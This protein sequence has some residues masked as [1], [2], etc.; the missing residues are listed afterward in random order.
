M[1]RKRLFVLGVDGAPPKENVPSDVVWASSG[2][3]GGAFVFGT[4]ERA[5]DDA[6]RALRFALTF[7][8][9]PH[10]ATVKYVN[11]EIEAGKVSLD[12]EKEIQPELKRVEP[13]EISVS[14]DLAKVYERVFVFEPVE[15]EHGILH[16]LCGDRHRPTRTRGLRARYGRFIG[17]KPE[18]DRL[19]ELLAQVQEDQ[20]QVV[21]LV[22]APGIGKTR[23]KIAF[24]E[25]LPTKGIEHHEGAFQFRKKEPYQA[26]RQ[27]VQAL[28]ETHG[29][30]LDIL[31]LTLGEFD[32]LDLL[33]KPEKVSDRFEGL[34]EDDLKKGLFFAVRKFLHRAA[35]TPLVLIFEDV[36]WA[37]SASIEL[38]DY[39]IEGVEKTKLLLILVHRPEID[40]PWKKKLNYSEIEVGPFETPEFEEFVKDTVRVDRIPRE[41]SST[42]ESVSL[43]NPLFVEEMVRHLLTTGAME[44]QT[45]ENEEK[46]LAGKASSAA[47]IPTTIHALIASRF[48]RLP[49]SSREALRWAAILGGSFEYE[50]Y[51]DLLRLAVRGEVPAEFQRLV[52]HRYLVEKSVF[53]THQVQFAHDLIHAVILENI[54]PVE[55][56]KM[57]CTIGEFLQKRYPNPSYE[58]LTRI[59]EHFF[60][61]E[62]DEKAVRVGL[63]AGEAAAN[64]YR[65]PEAARYLT[66]VKK[67]WEEKPVK[68]ISPHQLYAPLV[69]VLLNVAD[70]E[71]TERALAEWEKKKGQ[72]PPDAEAQLAYLEMCLRIGQTRYSE[73]LAASDRAVKSW[74]RVPDGK[75]RILSIVPERLLCFLRLGRSEAAISEGSKALEQLG[76]SHTDIRV[77]ILSRLAIC[78]MRMGARDLALDHIR[79]TQELITLN[80]PPQVRTACARNVSVVFEYLYMG[81]EALTPISEAIEVAQSTGLRNE[82]LRLIAHRAGSAVEWGEYTFALS[83]IATAL[84]ECRL[85]KDRGQEELLLFFWADTLA[86]LGAADEAMSKLEL[87]EKEFPKVLDPRVEAQ[88]SSLRGFLAEQQGLFQE[89][90]RFR[91]RGADLYEQLGDST[92]AARFRFQV[93]KIEARGNL[94]PTK[95]LVEIFN[96]LAAA[97]K[98]AMVPVWQHAQREAAYYLAS[99]GGKPTPGPE[100]EYDPISCPNAYFRQYLSVAKIHWLDSIGKRKEADELRTR[101]RAERERM[102]QKIPPQYH[103]TFDNHP[104]YRVPERKS[105]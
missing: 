91:T 45:L 98:D 37:D 66:E 18:L 32:Y 71:T 89:A 19:M 72:Q 26:F 55:A 69:R 11:V 76:D 79:K 51:L 2:P 16:L 92:Y 9:S 39:L 47:Q 77:L 104:L 10:R 48:D 8:E 43:G 87:L 31:G 86:D 33:V 68:E 56:R 81:P 29:T 21:G 59:A 94:R 64:L 67:R 73:A 57:H 75:F 20:G 36:H 35:K 58:M 12:W 84:A 82:L 83:E 44:V 1:E 63:E 14:S 15:E 7:T 80:L 22:G 74:A 90:A 3:K 99:L 4:K 42:L 85:M 5:E 101:Y 62:D 65:Y 23:L 30:K 61:G 53:P 93:I 52:D 49:Q 96:H 88:R 17:R 46:L 97:R 95:E 54:A 40:T 6:E 50:D 13:G 60:Q 100:A 103:K 41:V 34:S 28:I 105:H 27:I 25:T 38:L 78:A 70:F 102:K 24:R